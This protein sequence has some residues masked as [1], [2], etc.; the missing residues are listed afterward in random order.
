METECSG[1]ALRVLAPR[2][3]LAGDE[4]LLNILQNT[5]KKII[6]KCEEVNS[7]LEQMT[8]ALDETSISLQNVNNRFLALSNSQFI[9]SRVYEDDADISTDSAPAVETPQKPHNQE[10]DL[11]AIKNSL[12]VLQDHHESVT[13]LKDSDTETD[14]D[15]E[16]GDRVVL[17]AKDLYSERPLPYIIG[18]EAWKNSWHAGLIP[19][20]SDSESGSAGREPPSPQYSDS[21]P[22]DIQVTNKANTTISETSSDIAS[23]QDTPMPL[24]KSTPADIAADLARRLGAQQPKMKEPEPEYSPPKTVSKTIYKPQQPQTGTIFTDEPPPLDYQS[25]S[26]EEDIFAEVRINRPKM[27]AVDDRFARTAFAEVKVAPQLRSEERPLFDDEPDE[28]EDRPPPVQ[29]TEEKPAYKKPVGGISV[30][31]TNKGA[32]TIGAAILKRNQ[33][34]SSSEEESDYDER[35]PPPKYKAVDQTDSIKKEKDI[36]DDLFAKSANLEKKK[37]VNKDKGEVKSVAKDKVDL[38][39]DNLFDDVNDL[40]TTNVMKNKNNQKSIFDDDDDDLFADIGISVNAKVNDRNNEAVG[41]NNKSIFDSDDELFADQSPATNNKSKEFTDVYTNDNKPGFIGH[42]NIDKT[43]E[44]TNAEKPT[45]SAIDVAKPIIS[46]QSNIKSTKITKNIFDSDSDSDIFANF[47]KKDT[48]SKDEKKDI[49]DVKERITDVEDIFKS[50]ETKKGVL[51]IG[52]EISKMRSPSLFDDDED[53]ELF[54]D[55]PSKNIQKTGAL[56]EH[57]IGAINTL[58]TKEAENPVNNIPEIT[59]VVEKTVPSVLKEAVK[60][61]SSEDLSSED[62]NGLPEKI[63]SD[64]LTVPSH[65]DNSQK[66]DTFESKVNNQNDSILSSENKETKIQDTETLISNETKSESGTNQPMP[67]IIDDIFIEKDTLFKM[68]KDPISE[69]I[70]DDEPPVFEKPKE[71]KRSKNVNALFDDDS[72]DE[73]LFFRKSDMDDKSENFTSTVQSDRLF[74]IFHD[75]PPAIDNIEDDSDIFKSGSSTNLKDEN[76]KEFSKAREEPDYFENIPPADLIKNIPENEVDHENVT[77]LK[78]QSTSKDNNN[79]NHP[80][81]I[82]KSVSQ[83][84]EDKNKSLNIHEA[85]SEI[86]E[87]EF[88]DIFKAAN[89]VVNIGN[90]EISEI[91]IEDFI[92]KNESQNKSIKISDNIFNNSGISTTQLP[93]D[94]PASIKSGIEFDSDEELFRTL[95][96]PDKPKVPEISPSDELDKGAL[97]SKHGE[98][99]INNK[100]NKEN[101]FKAVHKVENVLEISEKIQPTKISEENLEHKPELS[102]KDLQSK[103]TDIK[104][105]GRIKSLNLNIDVSTLLPGA[106]PKKQKVETPKDKDLEVVSDSTSEEVVTTRLTPENESKMVKSISFEGEPNSEVLDNK[107]SKERARIQVKRRP[108]TRRARREAVR[109]SA[110][111]FDDST[112]NSSSIDDPPKNVKSESPSKTFDVKTVLTESSSNILNTDIKDSRIDNKDAIISKIEQV[113]PKDKEISTDNAAEKPKVTSKVVYI[114][115][116]EDIFNTKP[117]DKVDLFKKDTPI[118]TLGNMCAEV[119]KTETKPIVSDSAKKPS[120]VSIFGSDSEEELFGGKSKDKKKVEVKGSLFGDDDDDDLFGVKSKKADFTKPQ[121]SRTA[122]KEIEKSEPVFDDPLSMLDDDE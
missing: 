32:E 49:F 25:E 103:N 46:N 58:L 52:D 36:F 96:K 119:T 17:K 33:R 91:S 23:E 94:V 92:N 99:D 75:E 47:E 56:K 13:I 59:D 102:K 9:E 19:E 15:C 4:K 38:F 79:L 7:K 104:K 43:K 110:I 118:S 29:K 2:W 61:E 5:H 3:S 120:K 112:D 12:R 30:F 16:D 116:D 69:D 11:E 115:N 76:V 70:F 64:I 41:K 77:T 40:F 111:D 93:E 105:V 101:F 74:G 67:S 90:D 55:T 62:K 121:T 60:S 45:T 107:L 50:S 21:E 78:T 114:L 95:P 109:K 80:I 48:E 122:T 24:P 85:F 54:S 35:S 51:K 113:M 28:F 98:I 27:T 73:A 14:S 108:S 88:D 65:N 117:N 84:I 44:V 63:V 10:S 8:A 83:I 72:E 57:A 86:K 82:E 22:E 100:L 1:D 31:G 53:D 71:P 106:S 26:S 42:K 66:E 87:D 37:Q 81:N 89:K 39:S 68:D 34:K 20:D 97:L 18:S 6:S